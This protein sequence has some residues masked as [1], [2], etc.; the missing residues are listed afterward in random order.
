MSSERILRVAWIWGE[1]V[2]EERLYP[3]PTSIT[4]WPHKRASFVTPEAPAGGKAARFT[5][6]KKRAGGWVLQLAPSFQ[7]EINVGG[8]RV[9]VD[10]LAAPEGREQPLS[11]ADWGLVLLDADHGVSAFFQF[12]TPPEAVGRWAQ[13]FA[14]ATPQIAARPAR[15][16]SVAAAPC[17]G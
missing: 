5:L 3:S 14:D 12:V 6:F 9:A 15:L 13:V 17:D 1:Q 2:L 10:E 7:G 4:F 8:N 16:L 11:T